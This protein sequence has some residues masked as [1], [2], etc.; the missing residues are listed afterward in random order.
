[1]A[2]A[3]R[4]GCATPNAADDDDDDAPLCTESRRKPQPCS[5]TLTPTATAPPTDAAVDGTACSACPDPGATS[6]KFPR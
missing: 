5:D 6:R 3:Q 1:M 4:V 2:T